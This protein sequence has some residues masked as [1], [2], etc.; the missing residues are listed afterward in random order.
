MSNEAIVVIEREINALANDEKR[1][2]RQ[3]EKFEPD[4]D[5]YRGAHQAKDVVQGRIKALRMAIA[6]LN[7][8]PLEG[9]RR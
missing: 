6:V 8:K 2:D 4:T 1:L 9:L 3:L 5:A 7:A